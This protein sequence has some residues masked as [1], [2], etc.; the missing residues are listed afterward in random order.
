[1]NIIRSLLVVFAGFLSMALTEVFGAAIMTMAPLDLDLTAN[2]FL[3][4]V[5][6]AVLLTQVLM[7]FIFWKA[8]EPNP[9]RNSF[10]YVSAHAVFQAG[11]LSYFLNPP[12]DVLAYVIIIGASGL[13]VTTVFNRY[14]WCAACA[15]VDG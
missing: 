9:V 2:I 5:V 3:S 15:R 1:M 13:I 12:A 4:V 11:E 14:F 8:F 10:L 6:P 7:A